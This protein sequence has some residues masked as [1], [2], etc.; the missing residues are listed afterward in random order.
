VI[1]KLNFNSDV[2]TDTVGASSLLHI[3]ASTLVKWRSTGENNI[4]FIKIGKSVRY[5]TND[6]RAYV[7]RHRVGVSHE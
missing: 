2:L 3:P 7:E 1:R 4:P 5:S 6:L